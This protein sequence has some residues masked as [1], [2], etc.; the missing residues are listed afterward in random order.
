MVA[1][2]FVAAITALSPRL[3]QSAQSSD[4]T[5]SNVP[6]QGLPGIE[7]TSPSHDLAI[8]IV[9]PGREGLEL[10]ARL[11]DDGGIIERNISLDHP[12]RGWRDRL[13]SEA[14]AQRRRR[15]AARRLHCPHPLWRRHLVAAPSRLLEANRI[16]VSFVLNAGGLRVLPRVRDVDFPR[17]APKPASLRW[18]AATTAELVAMSA[19]SG[20]GHPRARGRL[21]RR[22]PLRR[23]QC[24]RP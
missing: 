20:R 3:A 15:G 12:Q 10:T 23:R 7:A 21:P 1:V 9:E 8:E 17:P 24:G 2:L 13:F 6:E 16:M 14:V 19:D 11:A 4:L 22:K 18:A 5:V